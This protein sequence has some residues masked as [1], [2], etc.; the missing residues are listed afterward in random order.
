M[1]TYLKSKNEDKLKRGKYFY[2]KDIESFPL[3][4]LFEKNSLYSGY[5]LFSSHFYVF[6]SLSI[7]N[8]P[9]SQQKLMLLFIF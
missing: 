3:F 9:R 6:I 7:V 2:I 4:L 8:F 1:N 5:S